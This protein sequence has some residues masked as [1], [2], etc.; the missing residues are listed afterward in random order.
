MG[1][2]VSAPALQRL[3]GWE[4][5]LD[6]AIDAYRARPYRLGTSDCLRLACD[7]IEAVT[8]QAHWHLFAGRYDDKATALR[9]IRTW[10]RTWSEAFGAFF[11]VE[12]LPPLLARRGDIVTYID[13]EPHLGVCVGAEV[14]L[15]GPEGLV[16]VPLA[17]PGVHETWRIG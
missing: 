1:A 10:G 11:G 6:A 9:L 4:L 2:G 15:Y 12:P 5:R 13:R 7:A 16:F 14:A 8:G 17:D 3:A